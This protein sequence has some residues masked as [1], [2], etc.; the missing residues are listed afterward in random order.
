MAY[1]YRNKKTGEV[2]Y[3]NRRIKSVFWEE[4]TPEEETTL[5]DPEEETSEEETSQEAPEEEPVAAPKKATRS[6]GKK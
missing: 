1:T 2:L 6:R 4:E 5:E 3:L